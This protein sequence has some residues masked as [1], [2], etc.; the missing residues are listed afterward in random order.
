MHHA[1]IE[2][3]NHD[4]SINKPMG[5]LRGINVVANNKKIAA[6]LYVTSSL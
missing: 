6:D 3:V 2:F 1:D 5:M 4:E